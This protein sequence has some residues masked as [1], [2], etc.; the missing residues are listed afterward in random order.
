MRHFDTV[1]GKNKQSWCQLVHTD[2]T[3]QLYKLRQSIYNNNIYISVCV[4]VCYIICVGVCR[5]LVGKLGPCVRQPTNQLVKMTKKVS[6]VW[7]FS[8]SMLFC[9]FL[10]LW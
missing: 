2:P 4:R 6:E 7:N 5:C 8:K 10:Y 3:F 9:L 1:D